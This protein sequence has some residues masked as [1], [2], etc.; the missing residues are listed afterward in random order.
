MITGLAA[1]ARL[2]PG[3]IRLAARRRHLLPV[4]VGESLTIG[5]QA[6]WILDGSWSYL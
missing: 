2:P 6:R 3:A 5:N 1:R 4:L